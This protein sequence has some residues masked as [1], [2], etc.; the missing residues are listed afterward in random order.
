MKI[1][2]RPGNKNRIAID[3]EQVS[4]R[5]CDRDENFKT[6]IRFENENHGSIWRSE[7]LIDFEMKNRIAIDPEQVFNA[8]V[9]IF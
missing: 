6:G 3:P 8:I 1:A 9:I 4:D 7:S 2:D 5:D